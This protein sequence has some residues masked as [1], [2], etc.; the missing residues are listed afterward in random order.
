MGSSQENRSTRKSVPCPYVGIGGSP[1]THLAYPSPNNFCYKAQPP[2]PV[3]IAHQEGF[4]LCDKY[5]NCP[6][7]QAAEL[8]PLPAEIKRRRRSQTKGGTRAKQERR[9]PVWVYLLPIGL[10]LIAA[11]AAAQWRRSEECSDSGRI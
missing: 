4:C 3:E 6:V 10:L 5:V 1:D 2:A 7:Y 9:W 11:L 8:Q